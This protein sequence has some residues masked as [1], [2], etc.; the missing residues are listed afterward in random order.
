MARMEEVTSG[1]AMPRG[2]PSSR[3]LSD[4]RMISQ[5]VQMIKTPIGGE[6]IGSTRTQPV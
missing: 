4:S 2:K 6:R 5:A 1:S 3:I